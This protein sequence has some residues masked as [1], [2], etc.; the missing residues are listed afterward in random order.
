MLRAVGLNITPLLLSTDK[1][2]TGLDIPGVLRSKSKRT[3]H[4]ECLAS[5]IH[6]LSP[7]LPSASLNTFT[8]V[9]ET[10]R[11][12]LDYAVQEPYL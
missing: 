12:R 11:G 4:V 10:I 2:N 7:S 9:T 1:R 6:P 3:A 5:V 8:K